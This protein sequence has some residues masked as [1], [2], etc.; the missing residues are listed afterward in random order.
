MYWTLCFS[1][2]LQSSSTYSRL[3]RLHNNHTAPCICTPTCAAP[4]LFVCLFTFVIGA[5][6]AFFVCL[7]P[8]PVVSIIDRQQ[9]N[10]KSN[11]THCIRRGLG[12]SVRAHLRPG[13]CYI[14]V[15]AELWRI[16]RMDTQGDKSLLD[17]WAEMR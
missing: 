13:M 12:R 7:F 6:V 5:H 16:C 1:E 8:L 3:H 4:C 2:H 15:L 9:A 10:A 17:A 11:C 14:L